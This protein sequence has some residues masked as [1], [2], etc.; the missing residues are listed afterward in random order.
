ML[1]NFT[2]VFS[3]CTY[4]RGSEQAFSGAGGGWYYNY[5]VF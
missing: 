1:I 2:L 4:L 5:K 3:T